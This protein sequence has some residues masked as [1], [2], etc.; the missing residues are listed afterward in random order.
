M[1]S[2][3]LTRREWL[4]TAAMTAV[5]GGA[6]AH[7]R[8]ASARP[9]PVAFDVPANA[10]DC[11]VHV[12]GD[13]QRFPF[14]ASRAYT[15]PPASVDAL[16]AMRA[17]LHT[18]RV[19]IVQPSVYG[20]DHRCLLDALRRIGPRA[21]GVAVVDDSITDA[22]LD[23]LD[24]AG[25][26]GVRLNLETGGVPDLDVIRQ[27]FRAAADRAASMGWHLQ[28][29]T[30]LQVVQAMQ[31]LIVT[32]PVPIV[33]DHFCQAGAAQGLGQPGFETLRRLL[34]ANAVYLKLSAPYLCSS[35]A[36]AYAD[37]ATIARALVAVNPRRLLW[38]SD[39]PH[40]NTVPV[41]GRTA[42]DTWPFYEIDDGLVFNQLAAWVP[43]AAMRQA[44]LVDTPAMVY[45]F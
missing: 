7:A 14:V 19:V 3:G 18:Q 5:A 4:A 6:L 22:D 11:H 21:R 2:E 13:P 29:F 24:D 41:P 36:P 42:T 28:L 37:M 9:T 40:V 10:C 17:A 20:T 38:G 34:E 43:E 27:R 26:C 16:N 8:Q 15:P 39:W 1:P 12:F 45:G 33:I 25:V 23:R 31:D 32:S 35:D 30:R 44:I